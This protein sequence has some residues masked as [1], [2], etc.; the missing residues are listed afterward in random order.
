MGRTGTDKKSIEEL[1]ISNEESIGDLKDTIKKSNGI[2]TAQNWIMII[3]TLSILG[4]T[5]VML[6]KL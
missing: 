6:K 4:A 2:S 5:I 3:L 1:R